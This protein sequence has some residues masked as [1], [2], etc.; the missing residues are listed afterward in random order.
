MR[1]AIEDFDIQ[2]RRLRCDSVKIET[3]SRFFNFCGVRCHFCADAAKT[4]NNAFVTRF[5]VTKRYRNGY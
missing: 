3:K 4:K 5:R 2:S 1:Y